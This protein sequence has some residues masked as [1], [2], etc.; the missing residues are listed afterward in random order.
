MRDEKLKYGAVSK[1]MVRI[2]E[3]MKEYVKDAR[4]QGCVVFTCSLIR[5]SIAQGVE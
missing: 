3:N 4:G 5:L 2:G 1:R